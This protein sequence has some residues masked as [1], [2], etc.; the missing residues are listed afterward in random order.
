MKVFNIVI[1]LTFVSFIGCIKK[2]EATLP[3]SEISSSGKP[4]SEL[5]IGSWNLT[6]IGTVSHVNS[7]ST[8]GSNSKSG[9]GEGS[10]NQSQSQTSWASTSLKE[11]LAFQPSG[12]FLK[13]ANNDAVCTGNY[14]VSDGA[15]YTK[16]GCSVSEQKQTINA[17]ST[18]TLIIEDD[19]QMLYRYDK[20]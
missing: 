17:I 15:I 9:C 18:T 2:E 5:I 1:L 8:Y 6:S 4:I 3:K 12:D 13:S 11:N 14:K 7:N 16:T 19:N 10:Q 20:Q